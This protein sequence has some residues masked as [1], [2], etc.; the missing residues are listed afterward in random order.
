MKLYRIK[1][2]SDGKF[3][4]FGSN[5][6][7]DGSF[8]ATGCF[9]KGEQTI[10]KHLFNLCCNWENRVGRDGNF[11]WKPGTSVCYTEIKSGP[12]WDR[13]DLYEVDILVVLDSETIKQPAKDFMGIL[14]DA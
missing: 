8:D 14:E 12:H 4:R 5:Y 6:P 13:L 7:W 1:R 10:K 2:L 11:F 9:F 3:F